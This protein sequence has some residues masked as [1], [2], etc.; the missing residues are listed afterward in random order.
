MIAATLLSTLLFAAAPQTPSEHLDRANALENDLEYERAADELLAVI[1]SPDATEEQLIEANLL[2]GIVKRV[3]GNNTEAR[4][5][6]LYV[7]KRR[8]ET[9][10]E[11]GRSP[12]IRSFFN[13]VR[14]EVGVAGAVDAQPL[15]PPEAV[16]QPPPDDA[17]DIAPQNQTLIRPTEPRPAPPPSPSPSIDQP[18][19]DA[20]ESEGEG[21]VDD[22]QEV[23]SDA[24]VRSPFPALL[25]GGVLATAGLGVIVGSIGGALFVDQLFFDSS[26]SATDRGGLQFVSRVLVA[27]ALA[28]G[29]AAA[30]G[31]GLM[32]MGLWE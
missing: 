9:T 8:P 15:M 29:A 17:P 10:L 27:T 26:R 22:T 24:S 16:G 1:T 5:H 12:K 31:A 11:K 6:F 19:D 23:A 14:E 13:L 7:L 25:G 18:V 4:L 2:A 32:A 21:A 28:G 20:P 30:G 3:L